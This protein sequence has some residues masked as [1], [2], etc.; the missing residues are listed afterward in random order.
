MID[1]SNCVCNNLLI[2]IIAEWNILGT[3]AIYSQTAKRKY[4]NRK[5]HLHQMQNK[6]K[7]AIVIINCLSLALDWFYV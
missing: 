7:L 4:K 1:Y 2:S 6:F 3:I 5:L